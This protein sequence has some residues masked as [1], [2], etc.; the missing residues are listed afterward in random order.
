MYQGVEEACIDAHER[1]W[2]FPWLGRRSWAMAWPW[3]GDHDLGHGQETTI[4]E[5]TL[6]EGTFQE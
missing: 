4:Q 3:A 6:Q 2:P 5:S 1:P